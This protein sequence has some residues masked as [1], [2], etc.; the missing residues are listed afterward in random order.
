MPTNC[1]GLPQALLPQGLAHRHLTYEGPAHRLATASLS[2]S[3]LLPGQLHWSDDEV[4]L[5]FVVR[6]KL[7]WEAVCFG[8]QELRGL[9]GRELLALHEAQRSNITAHFCL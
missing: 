3:L 5:A 1:L 8:G 9:P 2:Q 7:G 4:S 6:S